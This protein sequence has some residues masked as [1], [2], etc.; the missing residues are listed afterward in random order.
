[1]LNRNN[2]TVG[3]T[4][5]DC[6]IRAIGTLHKVNN[7]LG[8]I[9]LEKVVKVLISANGNNSTSFQAEY[10]TAVSTIIVKYKNLDMDR[11]ALAIKK[12]GEPSLAIH[13]SHMIASDSK[14]V[15]KSLTLSAM[16]IDMYNSYLKKNKLDKYIV[17]SSDAKNYLSE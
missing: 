12:L 6:I 14:S 4:P 16:I 11:L 3:D 8:I 17:L 9:N 13:K 15:T 2:V 1:M 10:I 5:G 7:K